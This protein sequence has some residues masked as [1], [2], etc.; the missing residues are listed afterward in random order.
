MNDPNT[1]D[2]GTITRTGTGTDQDHSLGD[3]E[4]LPRGSSVAVDSSNPECQWREQDRGVDKALSVMA[5]AIV[6]ICV[7]DFIIEFD[8]AEM[9][10]WHLLSLSFNCTSSKGSVLRWEQFA[11]HTLAYCPLIQNFLGKTG[12][13]NDRTPFT[14]HPSHFISITVFNAV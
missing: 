9:G 13:R 3:N 8:W 7:P 14:L 4:K 6:R 11:L 5:D 12:S 10:E 2:Y 1:V